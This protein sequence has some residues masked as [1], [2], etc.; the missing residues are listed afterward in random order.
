[1][2]DDRAIVYEE[3]GK[4][5]YRA[6]GFGRCIRSLV[7]SRRGFD[8]R[9]WP[10]GILAAMHAG[11]EW[12]DTLLAHLRRPDDGTLLSNWSLY[13]E[14]REYNYEVLPGRV[15][16]LHI[17]ALG[18]KF[19]QKGT[20]QQRSKE[21]T[22]EFKAFGPDLI[23]EFRQY[24]V[25]NMSHYAWQISIEG[26]ATGNDVLM[27]VADKPQSAKDHKPI[28][29][30]RLYKHDQLPFTR[31]DVVKRMI[32]ID[33]AYK[34]DNT[35]PICVPDGGFC[36]YYDYHDV[37]EANPVDDKPLEEMIRR[38]QILDADIKLLGGEKDRIREIL[39]QRLENNKP[40]RVDDFEIIASTSD[41]T[42][43]D[44]DGLFDLCTANGLDYS[45]FV[46]SQPSTSIRIK[47]LKNG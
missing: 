41:R 39:L 38:Y 27:V 1:M 19:T 11:N 13:G 42:S 14:Q 34:N 22:I 40:Y 23:R 12:E 35:L 16:R 24:G 29:T 10:T 47:K 33:K 25:A 32:E 5:I 7:L 30:S 31:M 15:I 9:P 45:Q 6:S 17:D 20:N 26:L 36:P 18:R 21:I 8:P 4:T 2:G 3:E 28:V 46:S 44:K 37:I 43:L